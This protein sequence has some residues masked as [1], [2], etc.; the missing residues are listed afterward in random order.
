MCCSYGSNAFLCCSV[1]CL[2]QAVT[3]GV[4]AGDTIG[5]DTVHVIVLSYDRYCRIRAVMARLA[6]LPHLK[7]AKGAAQMR[8]AL[9]QALGGFLVPSRNTLLLF[10]RD[11]FEYPELETHELLCNHLGGCSFFLI[12]Y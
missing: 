4:P 3:S 9:V 12:A 11:E 8:S 7:G 10:C 1:V 5:P 6:C 2:R